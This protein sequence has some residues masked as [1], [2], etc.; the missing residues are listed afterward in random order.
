MV[1][2]AETRNQIK[3]PNFGIN[4][5]IGCKSVEVVNSLTGKTVNG[6]ISRITKQTFFN[7]YGVL[8]KKL[9][10]IKIRNVIGDYSETKASVK[11]YQ[12]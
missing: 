8:I 6:K 3:A 2:S 7:R 4:W 12:V 1:T 5:T 11:D 9:P 10:N